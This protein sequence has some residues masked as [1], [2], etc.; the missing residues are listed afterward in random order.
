[1]DP[2]G[3]SEA[4]GIFRCAR[5]NLVLC[6]YEQNLMLYSLG[7]PFFGGGHLLPETSN[8]HNKL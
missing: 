8:N 5:T 6:T 3:A 4:Y 1:M 7:N 2:F